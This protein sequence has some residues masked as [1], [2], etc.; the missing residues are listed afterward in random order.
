MNTNTLLELAATWEKKAR[1]KD[2]CPSVISSFDVAVL[3]DEQGKY[4]LHPETGKR[5][6]MEGMGN[7]T[8]RWRP[9]STQEETAQ[10][11]IIGAERGIREGQLD[12][13]NDLRAL[14]KLLG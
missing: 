4:A 8:L 10:A 9:L 2:D 7:E 3:E 1:Q 12:C 11:K 5:V 13:A 14:V 6:N